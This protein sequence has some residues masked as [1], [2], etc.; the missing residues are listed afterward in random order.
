MRRY[1]NHLTTN[2]KKFSGQ[3]SLRDEREY[4]DAESE[5]LADGNVQ[6]SID[7]NLGIK[8]PRA[9]FQVIEVEF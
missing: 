2:G 6:E 1:K 4:S 5:F 9:V 7:E 3:Q 8:Q